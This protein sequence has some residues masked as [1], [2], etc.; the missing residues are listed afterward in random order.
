M[1]RPL[2]IL[3]IGAVLLAGASISASVLVVFGSRIIHPNPSG[4][5]WVR[6]NLLTG[7]YLVCGAGEEAD[8]FVYQCQRAEEK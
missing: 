5:G 2:A 8:R 7:D 1:T 4:T 3:L 6:E